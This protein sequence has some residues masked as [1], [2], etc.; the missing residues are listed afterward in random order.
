MPLRRFWAIAV[1]WTIICASLLGVGPVHADKRVALVIGNAAYRN[2]PQ[3]TNPR[4]DAADVD[5][6][7]GQA[8][9][10]P[11]VGGG[12]QYRKSFAGVEE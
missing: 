2:V 1:V 10:P 12:H 5:A 11:Q 3:L 7:V 4:N 9:R 6:K 8:T